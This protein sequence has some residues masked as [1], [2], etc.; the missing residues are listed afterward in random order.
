MW[1]QMSIGKVTTLRGDSLAISLSLLSLPILS[2][3]IYI[4]DFAAPFS[5]ETYV[6]QIIILTFFSFF[7]VMSGS[8]QLWQEASKRLAFSRSSFHSV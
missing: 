6:V 3:D 5:G 8:D 4:K 7:T 2:C 1:H